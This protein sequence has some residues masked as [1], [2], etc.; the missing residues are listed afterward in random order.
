MDDETVCVAVD[1]M[2]RA[3]LCHPHQCRHCANE[4]DELATHG[5]SCQWSEEWHPHHVNDIICRSLVAAKV[6]S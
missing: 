6:P 4:V 1:L 3:P 2:L 5:L